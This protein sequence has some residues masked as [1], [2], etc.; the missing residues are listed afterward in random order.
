MESYYICT[1]QGTYTFRV[2][3]TP[4]T[5]YNFLF[6]TG[7]DSYQYEINPLDKE[8]LTRALKN[9]YPDLESIQLFENVEGLFIQV[10][11]SNQKDQPLNRP[12][13]KMFK[14]KRQ[15]FSLEIIE[16]NTSWCIIT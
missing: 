5:I 16:K 1:S 12:E 3:S 13:F 14:S 10:I 2:T 4:V 15:D 9:I 7:E 6:T 11:N 8:F